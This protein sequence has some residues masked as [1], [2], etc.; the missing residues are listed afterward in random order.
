MDL[1]EP[2]VCG[3]ENLGE[4]SSTVTIDGRQ[5]PLYHRN[6]QSATGGTASEY[7]LQIAW[8]GRCYSIHLLFISVPVETAT[9]VVRGVV[10]SFRFAK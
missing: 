8:N 5:A 9:A 3:H 4:S 10:T 6:P 2:S 1:D 7:V